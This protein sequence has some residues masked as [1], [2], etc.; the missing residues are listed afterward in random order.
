MLHRL[1][2]T[3]QQSLLL[4]RVRLATHHLLH[5]LQCHLLEATNFCCDLLAHSVALVEALLDGGLFL[6]E[7]VEQSEE[8]GLAVYFSEGV[9]EEVSFL[10][11]ASI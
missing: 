7:A 10:S 8:G 4:P 9:P 3:H 5:L 6:L 1:H 2:R 11:L